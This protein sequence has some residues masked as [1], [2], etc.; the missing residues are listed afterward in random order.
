MS[1]PKHQAGPLPAGFASQ[2]PALLSQ[3]PCTASGPTNAPGFLTGGTVGTFMD[4]TTDP[5]SPTSS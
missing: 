4:V 3:R 5:F 1:S 2:H